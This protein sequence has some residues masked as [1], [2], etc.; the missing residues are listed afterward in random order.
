MREDDLQ[1]LFR[2]RRMLRIGPEMSLYV[3][4]MLHSDSTGAIPVIG[5]DARTGVA[6]RQSV[7]LAELR[8]ALGSPLPM[9]APRFS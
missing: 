5:A 7:D 6:Q 3:H 1:R 9:E 4:R 8:D 2:E